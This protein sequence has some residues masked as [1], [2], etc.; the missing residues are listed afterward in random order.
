[1]EKIDLTEDDGFVE[2]QGPDGE[3]VRLDVWAAN[4]A[5]ADYHRANVGKTAAD[6]NTGLV[7]LMAEMG[8][9]KCSH[10]QAARFASAVADRVQSLKKKLGDTPASP[11]STASTPGG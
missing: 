11:A 1:M 9:A 6:Y 7:E 2:V 10:F 4:N 3:A 5:L 8:L